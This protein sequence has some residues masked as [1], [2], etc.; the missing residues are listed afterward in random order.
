MNIIIAMVLDRQ[1]SINKGV[2]IYWQS[3]K[4]YGLSF[5]RVL[6]ILKH[7]VSNKYLRTC[8]EREKKNIG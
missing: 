6:T 3:I 4:S 8:I 2:I 5:Y 7:F 1:P